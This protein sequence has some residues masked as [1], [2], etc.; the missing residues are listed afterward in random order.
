MV[1]V[2]SRIGAKS[3]EEQIIPNLNAKIESL[4]LEL[5]KIEMYKQFLS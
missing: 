4:E 2:D 3:N 5:E 1:C